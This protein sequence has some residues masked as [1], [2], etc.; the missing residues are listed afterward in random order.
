MARTRPDMQGSKHH[1][2]KLTE[3]DVYDARVWYYDEPHEITVPELAEHYGVTESTMSNALRGQTWSH[4]K[5][6]E[7]GPKGRIKYNGA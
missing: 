5:Q 3:E 7:N 6:A 1:L 4:V 2:A